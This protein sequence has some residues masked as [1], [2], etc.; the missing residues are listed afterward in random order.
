MAEI[1]T[2]G[3]LGAGLMGHGIAQVA[4]QAGYDVVLREV[5]DDR[6][7]QGRRARSR[8][9][10]RRAVEKGKLEQADADAVRAR[11][12]RRRR[13]TPTSPTATS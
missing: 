4:A 8:S 1:K 3:V 13:T 10:S 7:A 6:L 11:I 9:S 5:D 12:H 2:V